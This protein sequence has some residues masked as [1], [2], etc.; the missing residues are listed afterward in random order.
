MNLDITVDGRTRPL[1]L[2][3]DGETWTIDGRA[4]S[5]LEVEPGVYSVL[6]GGRSFEARIERVEEGWA[7]QVGGR[8]FVLDVADPRRLERRASTRQRGGRQSVVAPM[9]GKVVR[10]LVAEGDG[11]EAGQGL[12]VIEAM[13]MQNEMKALKP[14][15][16]A[17]LPVREGATVTAG[18]V[19]AVV[20]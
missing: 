4:A 1:R 11:V 20:E 7:V 19:V 12:V 17:S 2:E 14:G 10:L 9:P 13:K 6:L 3:G 18:D 8:R 15:R 5:I 16:V